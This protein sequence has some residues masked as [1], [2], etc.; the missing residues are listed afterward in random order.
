MFCS[1][2]EFSIPAAVS[3]SRG[4]G[5]PAIGVADR[6]LVTMPPSFF[7][8]TMSSNSTP[9]AK[10]PLAARM[11]FCRRIPA[12]STLR[13]T[14]RVQGSRDR[15]RAIGSRARFAPRRGRSL[16]PPPLGGP[17]AVELAAGSG[18]LCAPPRAVAAALDL[19]RHLARRCEDVSVAFVAGQ[20]GPSV[21]LHAHLRNEGTGAIAAGE[22][23]VVPVAVVSVVVR[24]HDQRLDDRPR[25][26][27]RAPPYVIDAAFQ[28]NAV[29]RP[30][31]VLVPSPARRGM[32][33]AGRARAAKH[34]VAQ[35]SSELGYRR[36]GR[37]RKRAGW[38]CIAP[39]RASRAFFSSDHFARERPNSATTQRPRRRLAW[40]RPG[41]RRAPAHAA[42]LLNSAR[43][44]PAERSLRGAWAKRPTRSTLLGIVFL[45]PPT[46]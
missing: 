42:E 46:K 28:E 14:A 23:F 16:A 15:G 34:P 17:S 30:A 3:K 36:R 10:V 19:N 27:A 12:I 43:S 1:P 41:A 11:G 25:L 9:Y 32:L 35:K 22:E 31:A 7:K 38:R 45:G 6:P 5:L 39:A 26:L 18:V 44:T 40:R 24:I 21:A 29:A 20:F 8:L 33:G 37:R 4:L 2:T 13:S